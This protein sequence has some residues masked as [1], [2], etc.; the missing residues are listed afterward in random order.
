MT[1]EW[2][3]DEEELVIVVADEGET[4]ECKSPRSKSGVC[5]YA[6]QHGVTA[7]GRLCRYVP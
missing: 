1:A 5:A 2:D 4:E 6:G 3:D 7:C